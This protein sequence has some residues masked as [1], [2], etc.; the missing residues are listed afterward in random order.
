MPLQLLGHAIPYA[1]AAKARTFEEETGAAEE[2]GSVSCNVIM[3]GYGR[4]RGRLTET[5]SKRE[6]EINCTGNRVKCNDAM[7]IFQRDI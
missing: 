7:S 6:W 3:M 1:D 4:Q 2:R 5:F